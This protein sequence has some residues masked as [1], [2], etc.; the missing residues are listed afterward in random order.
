LEKL[1]PEFINRVH[2]ELG[3]KPPA[4]L[5]RPMK[6]MR[7]DPVEMTRRICDAHYEQPATP[8]HPT[9]PIG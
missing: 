8:S 2:P 3:C 7:V 5:E 6:T 1:V 4:D 9:K